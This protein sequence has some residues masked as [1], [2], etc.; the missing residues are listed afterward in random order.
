MILR[1]WTAAHRVPEILEAGR[2]FPSESNVS[3]TQENFGP[4]VVWLLPPGE[5]PELHGL[6][7]DK[8]TGWIDVDVPAIL[9]K[10]WEWTSLMDSSWREIFVTA[11][12][13][14]EKARLWY[15]FPAAIRKSRFVDWSK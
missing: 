9:W 4:R 15:V 12:G 11:G 13:G 5:S 2:I 10:D 6:S 1:H 3:I 7:D 8:R 14:W